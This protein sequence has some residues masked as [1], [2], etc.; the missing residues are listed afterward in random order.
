MS[1]HSEYGPRAV[2]DL[3]KTYNLPYLERTVK[4]LEEGQTTLQKYE[5]ALHAQIAR[6][7][8]TPFHEEVLLEPTTN[9]Y[10][11]YRREYRVTFER[12]PIIDGEP[13]PAL[14]VATS[15]TFLHTPGPGD[16]YANGRQAALELAIEWAVKHQCGIRSAMDPYQ[17]EVQ[18]ILRA[19]VPFTSPSSSILPREAVYCDGAGRVMN[20]RPYSVLA[21]R[22]E[23]KAVVA[24]AV[25]DGR[26]NISDRQNFY[27]EIDAGVYDHDMAFFIQNLDIWYRNIDDVIALF[28]KRRQ[29]AAGGVT[30]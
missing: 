29:L 24:Q 8:E 5:A 16:D 7:R 13:R 30:A 15:R 27:E 17:K 9:C 2:A 22:R 14:K 21:L 20:S 11:N 3:N 4:Y 12:T 28:E 26:I 1:L 23:Y 19:E 6:V 18:E 25:R 10:A